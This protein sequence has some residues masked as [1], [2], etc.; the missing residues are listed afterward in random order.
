[1]W[2]N[3][4]RITQS[5]YSN[6]LNKG[7]R[8]EYPMLRIDEISV[9]I[10]KGSTLSYSKLQEAAEAGLRSTSLS[11]QLKAIENN[12]VLVIR[13]KNP[14]SFQY[15]NKIFSTF[16]RQRMKIKK[17]TWKGKETPLLEK[18]YLEIIVS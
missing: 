16:T 10:E 8:K 3:N 15:S 17:V 12:V 18:G 7:K 13:L 6:N 4:K 5:G 1:M 9:K 11:I 14:I 2:Y